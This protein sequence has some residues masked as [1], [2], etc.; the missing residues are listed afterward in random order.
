MKSIN[1]VDLGDDDAA[2]EGLQGGGRSLSDISVSG[3]DSHLSGQHDVGG[4]L[5]SVGQ[6]LADSVQIVELALGDGVVDIDRGDLEFSLL[7]HLSQVVHSGGRLLRQ[8]ADVLDVLGVLL[9]DDVGQVASVVEDHVQGL[10]V[11]PN[12]GLNRGK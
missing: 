12:D 5:D 1:G 6:G 10:A 9:V 11:G 7:E 4:S 8:A 2:S 3:D